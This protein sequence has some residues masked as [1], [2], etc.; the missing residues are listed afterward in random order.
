MTA[1]FDE[2]RVFYKPKYDINSAAAFISERITKSDS[3][4]FLAYI[5][6]QVV[7]FTQIY[8]IFS[9]VSMQKLY[10]LNDLYVDPAHRGK[11]I[12][13]NLLNRGK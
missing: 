11:G 8:P 6:I 1:L 10:V 4:I 7:E 9:S 2:Y 3:A 5:D 13:K 12:G